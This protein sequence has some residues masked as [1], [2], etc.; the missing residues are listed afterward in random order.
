MPRHPILFSGAR[1]GRLMAVEIDHRTESHIWWRCLCDCGT[2]K[3][4][5]ASQLTG[6]RTRSCGCLRREVTAARNRNRVFVGTPKAEHHLYMTWKSM[7]ARCL[8]PKNKHF[9][10]YG[11]RGITICERWQSSF[12]AFQS[13]MGPRPVGHTLDRIDNDGNYEPKNCRWAT[14]LQQAQSRR[15]RHS[16]G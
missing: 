5:L 10:D 11:G 8:N 15:P 6:G 13:D 12:D 16:S 4:V 9:K 7:K 2:P 1:F 3:V 14:P